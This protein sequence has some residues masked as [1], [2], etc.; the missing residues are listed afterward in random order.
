MTTDRMLS[1]IRRFIERDD[2]PPTYRQLMEA[3]GL[4][5]L[6]SIDYWLTKL[7]DEGRIRRTP[8]RAR[9]IRLVGE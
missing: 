7:E 6:N 4:R 5:S 8:G 3:T 2:M 1:T 9:T